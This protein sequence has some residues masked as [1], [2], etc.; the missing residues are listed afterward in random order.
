NPN[1]AGP[2]AGPQALENFIHAAKGVGIR[3]E[4]LTVEEAD[5]LSSFDAL[6]IRETTKVN[7]HTYRFSV[8]AA[9]EGLVVMDDP[10]SILRC[11]NKVYMQELLERHHIRTPKSLIVHRDTIKQVGSKLGYPLVLKEPD[12][13]FSLGVVKA[14]NEEE[15]LSV[16]RRFFKQSDLI[17]AQEY[18]P[19]SYDWRVGI[20][21]GEALYACQYGMAEGHWQIV[22]R[23]D[24]VTENG[25]HH[26]LAIADAP[27]RVVRL[28]QRAAGL[29]GKGLYGVDVKSVGGK[30]Y[31][32]EVNDNPNV[33]AG[34]EDVVLGKALYERIMRSF[35]ERLDQMAVMD[36]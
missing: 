12:S 14:Q 23:E 5:K 35:R 8:R 24:G 11:T 27:Q 4:L 31:V 16:S 20:I 2:P 29:V 13:G 3:A 30:L 6:F 32:I 22:K 7:H 15:L 9:T 26:T 21:D 18:L 19:T 25:W 34:V 1:E 36:P 33:D 10:V 28:A 17:I